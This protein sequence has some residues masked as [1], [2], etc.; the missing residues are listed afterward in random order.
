MVEEKKYPEHFNVL[1]F[2][3]VAPPA[4]AQTAELCIA[5][6]ETVFPVDWEEESM[7]VYERKKAT[8]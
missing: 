2:G 6:K 3:K 8:S 1:V 7:S 4:L 5:G